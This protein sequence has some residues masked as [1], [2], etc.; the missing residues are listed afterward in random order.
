MY[1][2]SNTH[3]NLL[4]VTVLTEIEKITK[5]IK[6]IMLFSPVSHHFLSGPNILLHRIFL[7]SPLT[8]FL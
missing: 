1:S 3:L 5:L 7:H 8:F 4:N 2:T 6:L